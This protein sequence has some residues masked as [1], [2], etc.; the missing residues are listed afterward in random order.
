MLRRYISIH[1]MLLVLLSA[2]GSGSDNPSSTNPEA[3][4]PINIYGVWEGSLVSQLD[5]SSI[6]FKAII[7]GSRIY[8]VDYY[9]NSAVGELQRNTD[10]LTATLKLYSHFP[11]DITES[12]RNP[13]LGVLDEGE[14]EVSI[15]VSESDIT[16]SYKIL[17]SEKSRDVGSLVFIKTN[18]STSPPSIVGVYGTY[19]PHQLTCG[20]DSGYPL[21]CFSY[22]STE[23]NS[24]YSITGSYEDKFFYSPRPPSIPIS[25]PSSFDFSGHI[26]EKKEFEGLY[27]VTVTLPGYGSF[28]GVGWKPTNSNFFFIAVSSDGMFIFRLG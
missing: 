20:Q 19:E 11:V 9:G 5:S 21:Y 3:Q 25:I 1:L 6:D 8:L 4:T 14:L 12:I 26:V 24:D 13:A 10:A 7:D 18:L 27:G 28:V 2:C 16:G 15:Y 17:D 22:L 23:I